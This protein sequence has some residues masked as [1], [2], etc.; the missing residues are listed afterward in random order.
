MSPGLKKN[1]AVLTGLL[2][3]LFS[4]EVFALNSTTL[5]SNG[6]PS[7]KVDI[8]FLGDGY[9]QSE[10]P[11]YAQD[12]Q[13]FTEYLFTQPPFSDYK[14]FFNVHRVDV[15]S[16]QSGT[17]NNCANSF[18][19]T[20][21]DTGFYSTGQD[22]RL[23]YTMQSQKVYN[24]AIFAPGQDMILIIVNT[25]NYGG[26]GGHYGVFYRGA[27][28]PEVMAHEIGHSFGFLADEYAYGGQANYTGNEPLELNVTINTNRSTLKWGKW[29][30]PITAIPTLT[31]NANTPG[32]YRGGKYSH[33]GIYRPTYSS[34]MRSVYQPFEIVNQALLVDRIFDYVPADSTPPTA[35]L[36]ISGGCGQVINTRDIALGI[37]ARDDESYILAYRVSENSSFE[38]SAWELASNQPNFSK[39]VPWTLSA[40]EGEK[41]VYL[42]IENGY[43]NIAQ[44]QCSIILDTTPPTVGI[45]A[46]EN[47]ATVKGVVTVSA[48]VSDNVGVEGVKFVLDNAYLVPELKGKPNGEAYLVSWDTTLIANGPHTLSVGARDSAGNSGNHSITVIV[49]NPDIIPPT[50]YIHSPKDGDTVSDYVL[51]AA[52]ARDDRG[53]VAKV[54]FYWYVQKCP[55]GMFCVDEREPK[56]EYGSI[57]VTDP[58]ANGL[59]EFSLDTLKLENG[60]YII[61]AIAYDEAGNSSSY[62]VLTYDEAIT[63]HMVDVPNKSRIW[64]TVN[65]PDI[66]PPTVYI[67]SPKNGDTVKG[68]SVKVSMTGSEDVEMKGVE[69]SLDESPLRLVFLKED[70]GCTT[71]YPDPSC[72]RVGEYL[73][74]TTLVPNGKHTLTATARDF[75]GNMGSHSITVDV[76]NPD[77][78]APTVKI[79]APENGATVSGNVLVAAEAIDDRKVARV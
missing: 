33:F 77:I 34:K 22:C 72:W 14:N 11:T 67:H 45:T 74:D 52:E 56:W 66:I 9:T 40:G 30:H 7:Q 6:S 44:S 58:S 39:A 78:I 5:I 32:L 54:E 69:F 27:A 35:A 62:R 55:P 61:G 46:P 8:V 59:Y 16:N 31:A 3:T 23:L 38:N 1:F 25:P 42:Q 75:A 63:H 47:G 41:T 17:D 19:D 18:V 13:E 51:V 20:A 24:A 64:V 4:Q 79:T 29:I 2:L 76:N 57:V 21:L 60:G 50:V 49:N 36:T 68:T 71:K 26:A 53:K 15:I 10:M 37:N 12:V 28:G 73:W 65:N 48:D 70:L 43:G